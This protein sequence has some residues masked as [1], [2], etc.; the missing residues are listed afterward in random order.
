M[1]KPVLS[2]VEEKPENRDGPVAVSNVLRLFP[3][4]AYRNN[5]CPVLGT[6]PGMDQTRELAQSIYQ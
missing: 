6:V 4:G 3:G 5:R 1:P 2:M